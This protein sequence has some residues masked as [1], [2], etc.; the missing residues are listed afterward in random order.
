ML[1]QV[2]SWFTAQ[3]RRLIDA[4]RAVFILSWAL[5]V[6]GIVGRVYRDAL[7]SKSV[8]LENME[9][10]YPQAFSWAIPESPLGFFVAVVLAI[11]GL[12]AAHEGRRLVVKA[13][14][15]PRVNT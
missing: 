9:S 6:A 8:A 1:V 12:S 14:G 7:A 3:P 2:H 4:G 5:V 10:L 11:A 15:A 13:Q